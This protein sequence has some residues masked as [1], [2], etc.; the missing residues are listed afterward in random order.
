MKGLE[1]Q[2]GSLE[3]LHQE[4][5]VMGMENSPLYND[6]QLAPTERAHLRNT[7]GL[8]DCVGKKKKKKNSVPNSGL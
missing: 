3:A 6:L 1:S 8:G 2:V 7:Q 5:K 4:L